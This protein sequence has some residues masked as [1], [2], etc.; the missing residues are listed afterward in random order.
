MLPQAGILLRSFAIK[1]SIFS[2]MLQGRVAPVINL[3]VM[4]SN[5]RSFRLPGFDYASAGWYFV[6]I[7]CHK[8]KHL[9]AV[10]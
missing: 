4:K 10:L 1:D 8:R 6:R 7:I 9:L 2:A 3:Q 5:H